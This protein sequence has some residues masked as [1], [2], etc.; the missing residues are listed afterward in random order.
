VRLRGTPLVP[1]ST[2]RTTAGLPHQADARREGTFPAPLVVVCQSCR[3]RI[4]SY[5]GV[6]KDLGGYQQLLAQCLDRAWLRTTTAT[7]QK[8]WRQSHED[9]EKIDGPLTRLSVA[10]VRPRAELFGGTASASLAPPKCLQE[11]R[12]GQDSRDEATGERL[13]NLKIRLL[14]RFGPIR[15]TAHSSN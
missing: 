13:D 10:C 15:A 5:F 7:P 14:S 12:L 4:F 8:E 9:S 11:N 1:I 3:C 6:V 2:A